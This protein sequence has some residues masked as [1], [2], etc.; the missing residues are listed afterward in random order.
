MENVLLC[1]LRTIRLGFASS[2][3]R[4]LRDQSVE[5]A[6]RTMPVPCAQSIGPCKPPT[7]HDPAT[8][9]CALQAASINLYCAIR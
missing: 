8:L 7:L 2:P 9:G 4:L 3:L 6:A 5:E 1:S